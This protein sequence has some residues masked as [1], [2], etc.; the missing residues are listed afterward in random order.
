[1]KRARIRISGELLRDV[2][3]LPERCR[4][5]GSELSGDDPVFVVESDD[6]PERAEVATA[7]PTFKLERYHPEVRFVDW[8]IK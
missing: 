5:V 7:T 1:M 3:R 2:L 8:G 6:L 4:V